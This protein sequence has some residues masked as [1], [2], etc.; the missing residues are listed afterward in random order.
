MRKAY[1]DGLYFDDDYRREKRGLEEKLAGLVFP[2]ADAAEEAGNL[3]QQL[4]ELWA[5]GS[6][7]ERRQLL[8]TMLDAIYV[9]SKED[10][11]I[12]VLKPKP[13]F[14]A[15]F[16]IAT[17]REGSGVV[18][19]NENSPEA[20][21][22]PEDKSPCFW[23]RRGGGGEP[24]SEEWFG[25]VGRSAGAENPLETTRNRGQHLNRPVRISG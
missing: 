15:V 11:A 10:R 13:A 22:S 17:T 14:R 3:I 8:L 7:G 24:V 4:P 9:D 18:L 21:T 16:Q 23:W 6:L 12:V 5:G 1:V 20:F 19:Y 25:G 2:E